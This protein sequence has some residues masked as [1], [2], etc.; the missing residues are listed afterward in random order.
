MTSKERK[1]ITANE[2]YLNE[3]MSILYTKIKATGLDMF[4]EDGTV[5]SKYIVNVENYAHGTVTYLVSPNSIKVNYDGTNFSPRFQMDE[6]NGRFMYRLKPIGMEYLSCDRHLD[7]TILEKKVMVTIGNRAEYYRYLAS[8]TFFILLEHC[9]KGEEGKT[10]IIN[11]IASEYSDKELIQYFQEAQSLALE[12]EGDIFGD[13]DELSDDELEVAEEMFSPS[14]MKDIQDVISRQL[15]KKDEDEIEA[16]SCDDEYTD[17]CDIDYSLPDVLKDNETEEPYHSDYPTNVEDF[18]YQE[19]IRTIKSGTGEEDERLVYS[20][21][22]VAENQDK[23]QDEDYADAESDQDFD[24]D[25]EYDEVDEEPTGDLYSKT[26]T[27]TDGEGFIE[28]SVYTITRNDE[29]IDGQLKCD[30]L[31]DAIEGIMDVD[32]QI[33]TLKDYYSDIYTE[34]RKIREIIIRRKERVSQ[35]KNGQSGA[36]VGDS[37]A[38]DDIENR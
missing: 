12:R 37:G 21:G 5:S 9:S 8:G 25:D 15:S 32:Q 31:D 1:K 33:M 10:M 13:G 30:I 29:Q 16:Y 4:K 2:L 19:Y 14:D 11:E 26:D 28:D 38:G 27:I 34:L 35:A 6:E 36:D 17:I 20:T 24:D 23:N 22:P 18:D 7:E 3:C